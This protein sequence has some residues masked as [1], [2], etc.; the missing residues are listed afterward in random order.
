M[1]IV[2]FDIGGIVL[3]MGVMVCD[4]RLLEIVRQLINDSD[5]D[6]IL[7]VMLL[8]LVVYLL[9]EGIVI[10]VLGYIDLY[11]GFIIMGGVIC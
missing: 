9:C 1:K 11:S 2:V 3:K 5:G 8:W 6:W 7:Q 4:G 10:S